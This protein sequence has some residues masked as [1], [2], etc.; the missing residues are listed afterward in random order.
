MSGVLPPL[1]SILGPQVFS[2]IPPLTHGGDQCLLGCPTSHPR[3]F[4]PYPSSNIPGG[5]WGGPA[6]AG[7]CSGCGAAGNIDCKK[8]G[9]EGNSWLFITPQKSHSLG[10][11]KFPQGHHPK[12]TT[13]RHKRAADHDGSPRSVSPRPG[14]PYPRGSRA[15]EG[16][17][18]PQNPVSSPPG[19]DGATPSPPPPQST[20][21]A[22]CPLPQSRI[23]RST[24]ARPS[25]VPRL[26]R[27]GPPR[28]PEP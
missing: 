13:Q 4:Q 6:C 28:I 1:P 19:Q 17:W 25:H 10:A 22:S 2:W 14:A 23:C 24:G 16:L 11:P 26:L 5:F 3:K 8:Q 7:R 12:S 21:S 27:E 20:E 9:E 18:G 15:P